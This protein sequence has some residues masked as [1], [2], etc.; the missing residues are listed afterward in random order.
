MIKAVLYKNLSRGIN[1]CWTQTGGGRETSFTLGSYHRLFWGFCTLKL[2]TRTKVLDP[3][4]RYRTHRNKKRGN[5]G[6]SNLE[7]ACDK[8]QSPLL[9][10]NPWQKIKTSLRRKAG[11]MSFIFCHIITPPTA[12]PTHSQYPSPG[13]VLVARGLGSATSSPRKKTSVSISL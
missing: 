2:R 12:L 13:L 11:G 3:E 5:I 8:W 4:E 1:V 10:G 7:Q 9:W 6:E